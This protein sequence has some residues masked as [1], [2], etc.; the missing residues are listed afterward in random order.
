LHADGVDNNQ[1][2]EA[3]LAVISTLQHARRLIA[4]RDE[5]DARCARNT[6]PSAAHGRSDPGRDE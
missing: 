5:I 2:A 3:T 1:G 4:C 6:Y